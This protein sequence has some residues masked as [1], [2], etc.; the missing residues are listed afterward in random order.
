[1]HTSST[2]DAV[3]D[4]ISNP[5]GA[6]ARARLLAEVNGTYER[7]VVGLDLRRLL[8]VV[9]ADAAILLHE[10]AIVGVELRLVGLEPPATPMNVTARGLPWRMR[11]LAAS[12]R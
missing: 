10:P 11:V 9:V 3:D 8:L 5:A 1:M 4:E 7:V 6:A 12:I 2:P